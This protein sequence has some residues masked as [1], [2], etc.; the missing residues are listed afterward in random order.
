MHPDARAGVALAPL[1]F[2][3][4]RGTPPD[5]QGEGEST[6][7]LGGCSGVQTGLP[8]KLA[9]RAGPGRRRDGLLGALTALVLAWAPP[10][11]GALPGPFDVSY[12]LR[13]SGTTIA[14]TRWSL[15]AAGGD[16]FVYESHSAT[17]GIAKL[18]RDVTVVER[19]EWEQ[20][21]NDLRS[22]SYRYS[23]T[24]RRDKQVVVAFDWERGL[25]RNT[26]R[27]D[28]WQME[29]PP[30]TLDKLNY[31]LALMRDLAR[32][33]ESVE[34]TVADGGKL[35][36]YRFERNGTEVIET[37]LGRLET[38]RVERIRD[39]D[40]PRETTLWCAPSLGFLPVRARHK[41]KDGRVVF[42]DVVSVDGLRAAEP[43]SLS[44]R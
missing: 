3:P 26:V 19:S 29:I 27:G 12:D 24:G 41:E 11:P 36:P 44:D 25:V 38:V 31:F 14:R 30:G 9:G 6:R 43:V 33:H 2:T 5:A 21:G 10:V 39:S 28:S 32:G 20:L 40:S 42:W 17:V 8:V 1:S 35:K 37:S 34:Y 23:R 7:G 16:R 13:T 22:L 15:R 4:S 18:F